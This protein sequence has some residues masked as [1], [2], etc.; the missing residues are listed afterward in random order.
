MTANNTARTIA[1]PIPPITPPM[2]DFVEDESPPP[3]ELLLSARVVA[4]GLREM[5]VLV[6][7]DLE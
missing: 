2:T 7:M 6:A 3:E 4:V 1:P 5:V